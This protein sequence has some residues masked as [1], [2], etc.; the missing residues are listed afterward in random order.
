M[1]Q[2]PKRRKP[3]TAEQL[4][5]GEEL[6]KSKKRK[7]DIMDEGREHIYSIFRVKDTKSTKN[8]PF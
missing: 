2:E 1:A 7:R 3:L 6:V 8:V 5:L 4:A